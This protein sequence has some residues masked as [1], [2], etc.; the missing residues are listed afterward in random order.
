MPVKIIVSNE[1]ETR[2]S[3]IE[4]ILSQYNITNPHPDLMYL[5]EN[6]KLG[7]E[8]IKKVINFLSMKPFQAMGRAVIFLSGHN[9]T[10]DSQNALLKTLEEIPDE[11]IL[12]L[13]VES[14]EKLLPTIR[15]RSAIENLLSPN[16]AHA[17]KNEEQIK[18]LVGKSV[19]DRFEFIDKLEEKE[20]FLLDLIFFYEN[21]IKR[22]E[23]SVQY[24]KILAEAQKWKKQNVNI[25]PILE[26][27]MLE[28][29]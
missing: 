27:L 3:K 29:E 20:E 5:D 15:S 8:Q 21:R 9:L 11:N 22:G 16:H 2:S 17:S 19:Q 1:I 10:L 12:V 25:K 7:I 28:L 18:G 6:T 24:L 13:A 26:Y 23:G 4:E 14:E